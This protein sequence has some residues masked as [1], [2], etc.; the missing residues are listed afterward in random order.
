MYQTSLTALDDN[1]TI[2][3]DEMNLAEFPLAV[4]STRVNPKI[5]TLEFK[6][7]QRLRTGESIERQW[8]I[9]AADKF[10]L[11]TASDDDVVLG[12]IKLSMAEHFK[13]PKVYFSRYELLK[14]LNWS[15]EG[16]NYTRLSKALDR[17]SGVRIRAENSFYDNSSKTNTTR[18]F[19]IIDAYEIK[20]GRGVAGKQSFFIWSEVLFNSF[21]AGYI[22]K[23]DHEFYFGL[24][25]AVARRLYRYLDKHF[26][27]RPVVERPLMEFAFEK[28]GLSR[29]YKYVSTV[30]QQVEPGLEELIEKGFLDSY[31]YKGR[32][33][34][35]FICFKK[36]SEKRSTGSCPE[37][38]KKRSHIASLLVSRGLNLSQSLNL[39]E[40]T[41]LEACTRIEAII[42][43]YDHL[44]SKGDNR[45][46]RNPVG[47]LY[48]AVENPGQFTL[49][50]QFS[51]PKQQSFTSKRADRKIVKAPKEEVQLSPEQIRKIKCSIE[52]KLGSLK[53]E[54]GDKFGQIVD[55]LVAEEIK[56]LTS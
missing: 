48:R 50:G 47:F 27:F 43:Y 49:P 13:S 31:E 15:T 14:I 8:T 42:T 10:G 38:E 22:K 46:S 45:V 21:K 26:Y 4:L 44:L 55:K 7:I 5:K 36:R 20:N 29:N 1:T 25:S 37:L 54:M 52:Q 41:T 9:T 16:R 2:G 18:N 6:D 11:P 53:D 40:K 39:L 56:S 51:A 28:L 32:G 12:L 19:G 35:T 17:L 30:K 3:R 24:Q 23:L 34:N 33:Q